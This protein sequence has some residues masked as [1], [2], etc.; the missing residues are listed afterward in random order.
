[1]K[2]NKSV[3]ITDMQSYDRWKER[4]TTKYDDVAKKKR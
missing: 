4:K 1:M 2:D 3:R